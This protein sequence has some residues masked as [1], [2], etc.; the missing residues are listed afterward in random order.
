MAAA[1][2]SADPVAV[3]QQFA[4]LRKHLPGRVVAALR[5]SIRRYDYD[6]ALLLLASI[7]A[8]PKE[9]PKP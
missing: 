4:K 2:I 7:K 5:E 8:L 3:E 6:H 9:A 1:L